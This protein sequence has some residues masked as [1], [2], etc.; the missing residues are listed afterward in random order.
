MEEKTQ[1]S[2]AS[3][4]LCGKKQKTH[5]IMWVLLRSL[6][7]RLVFHGI[8]MYLLKLRFV[9]VANRLVKCK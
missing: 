1:R 3:L 5:I 4:I 8:W 6:E 7:T 9:K 2:S